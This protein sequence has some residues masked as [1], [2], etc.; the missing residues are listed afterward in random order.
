MQRE[1]EVGAPNQIQTI[2]PTNERPIP[3]TRALLTQ[4][5]MVEIIDTEVTPSA[6]ISRKFENKAFWSLPGVHR[7]ISISWTGEV[8][9]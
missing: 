7:M 8:S 4:E 2:D 3:P 9:K 6:K 5:N 1:T